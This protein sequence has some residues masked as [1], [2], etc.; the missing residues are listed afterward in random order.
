MFVLAK[1]VALSW[2]VTLTASMLR[3]DEGDLVVNADV[4]VEE[5]E[6]EEEREGEEEEE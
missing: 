3:G 6:E 2:Q 1:L 5:E 4:E